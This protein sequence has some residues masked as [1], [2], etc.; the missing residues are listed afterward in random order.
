MANPNYLALSQMF[1]QI[2][3]SGILSTINS[4]AV[5]TVPASTTAKI[6][7]GTIC[8]QA[9]TTRTVT[10]GQ[11]TN[12]SPTVSSATANFTSSDVGKTISGPGIPANATITAV[13]SSTSIT[14]SSTATATASGVALAW[15]FAAA[16]VTVSLSLHKSGDVADGTH[17]VLAQVP[18]A[19]GDTLSLRD[20]LDGAM[21]ATGESV[22]LKASQANVITVT[23]SG[24]VAS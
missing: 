12:G 16:T 21:L 5:Y 6:T 4:T 3:Y 9:G 14:I 23:M 2:L 19:A 11:T 1:G 17:T 15:G 7:H 8:N 24:A 18:V 20:Y 13:G 10:D 22:W